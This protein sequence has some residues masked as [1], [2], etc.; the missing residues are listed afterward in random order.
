M[1]HTCIYEQERALMVEFTERCLVDYLVIIII[2]IRL[3]LLPLLHL[4]EEGKKLSYKLFTATNWTGASKQDIH[5]YSILF[6]IF[7]FFG[8]ICVILF[9]YTSFSPFLLSMI[10][11]NISYFS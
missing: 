11:S 2:T 1:I 9:V 3:F 7:F 5:I 4:S 6:A 8:S 10:D